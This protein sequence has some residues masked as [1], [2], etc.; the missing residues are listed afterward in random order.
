[1]TIGDWRCWTY[2]L[3]NWIVASTLQ[4]QTV[5][6]L[7][8]TPFGWFWY[9]VE[10]GGGRGWTVVL[11]ALST[12]PKIIS[13]MQIRTSSGRWHWLVTCYFN[14]SQFVAI[15]GGHI[16]RTHPLSFF[17]FPALVPYRLV[18]GPRLWPWSLISN[19]NE[20]SVAQ[21]LRRHTLLRIRTE[22]VSWTYLR[23]DGQ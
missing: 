18:C 7:G 13:N 15:V 21:P 5:Y 9:L 4:G 16:S 23:L 2:Q 10:S 8:V 6:L 17:L 3:S 22:Q 19:M 14:Q 20:N 11:E 12:I 1:M